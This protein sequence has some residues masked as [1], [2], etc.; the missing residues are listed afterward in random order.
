MN[1][2][3]VHE[4]D[5]LTKLVFD[6]HFLAEALSLR[7][8]QVFAI[9]YENMWSRDSLLDLGSLKTRE[10][11]GISRAFP[12]AS[13]CLRHPGFI[14][15]A[16]LSRISAAFTHYLEIRRTIRQKGID[17]IVLYS[18]PT[19]GL[20]AIHLAR[21]FNIPVVF[22]SIDIL[23]QLVPYP[24]LR[25]ITRFIEKKVYS[26]VDVIL[27][28]TPGLSRYVVDLGADQ[29]KVGLLPMPVDTNL[30][31][32]SP[33]SAEIRQQWGLSDKAQIIVFI[34]TLFEFSG[35]DVLIHQF[36]EIVRQIPEAKLLIVG[37]GPQRP[38]LEG[39]IAELGLKEQVIITGFQPYQTMPQYINLAAVC[40][41]PFLTT[42]ATRNILP[43]KIVQY[44]A[45]GKPV[46]ATPLPGTIAVIAGEHQG[47]VYV[48]N[49][50]DMVEKMLSLLKSTERRQQLGD[51]G[52]NYVRQVHSYEAIAHQLESR[53]KEAIE[54]KQRGAVS[55]RI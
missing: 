19:N 7:G 32:P 29:A 46:I 21:R 50:G 26:G 52:L 22:R 41:N 44:L 38:K 40:I 13:V 16:G 5:W 27:T 24:A 55:K 37:D 18:V 8:H 33:D 36:P 4:V 17:A 30:F 3:F 10:F 39:I 31:Q 2:L 49:G 45:C 12:G 23:H 14:K 20:Q 43:G 47:V 53:L 28:L 42:D 51:A 6:M 25:S 54:E 15:I 48:N 34:G 9:D 1:I 11:D 35:L